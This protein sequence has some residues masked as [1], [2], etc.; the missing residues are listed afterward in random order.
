V[1]VHHPDSEPTLDLVHHLVS[2]LAHQTLDQDSAAELAIPAAAASTELEEL[3]PLS[4]LAALD[5]PAMLVPLDSDQVSAQDQD[6]VQEFTA[7][8]LALDSDQESELLVSVQDLTLVHLPTAQARLADMDSTLAHP[9]TALARLADL[10][11]T[12]VHPALSA[13]DS[14]LVPAHSTV[15]EELNPPEFTTKELTTLTPAESRL[16]AA[17]FTLQG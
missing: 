13:Q 15:S 7:R 3:N 16:E 2:T 5:S 4:D 9:P 12:L 14:A 1:L 8:E 17:D 11:T 6:S 10:D